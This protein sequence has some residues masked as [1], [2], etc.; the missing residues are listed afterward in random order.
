MKTIKRV[1]FLLVLLF[2][3]YFLFAQTC[4]GNTFNSPGAPSSC[5]YEY[6]TSGWNVIPPSNISDGES[7]CILA[8][9]ATAFGTFR[10]DLFIADGAT[11]SGNIGSINSSST[12]VVA[13]IASIG[14]SPPTAGNIYVEETGIYNAIDNNYSPTGVIYNAGILNASNNVALGGSVTVYNY[15]KATFNVQGDITISKPFANCGL[16]E[17]QGDLST[18]GSGGLNNGCS[19]W[20]HGDMTINSDYYNENL[21]VL[22]GTINFNGA[23]FYNNDILMVNNINLSGD[24]LIGNNE[25]SVLIVR[26]N[27]TLT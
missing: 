3:H 12:I 26:Y 21:I 18:T 7:V 4:N 10:G 22:E 27:S 2:T 24:H 16:L 9:N 17:V 6:T 23:D 15:N 19:T 11:Y 25:T 14:G 13:G 20:I 8:D 1:L 5:T